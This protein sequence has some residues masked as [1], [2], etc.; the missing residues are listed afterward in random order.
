M[1]QLEGRTTEASFQGKPIRNFD[2]TF[3]VEGGHVVPVQLAIHPNQ[4][5]RIIVNV[6][7]VFGDIDGYADKYKKLATHV[8]SED[9]AAVVRTA[10]WMADSSPDTP[11]RAALQY[12]RDHA[13]EIAG[14]TEPEVMLMG[15]SAGASA[16]ASTA[17][18]YPEVTKILL[19]APSGDMGE[20]E[21]RQ[22]LREFGGEVYVVIGDQD[23]IVGPQAGP[24]FYEM[25][26]GA[27]FRDLSVIPDCGHQFKGETNGRIMSQAPFYAFAAGE[28]P[29]FPNPQ[30]GIVLYQ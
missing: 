5:R 1:A 18:L 17:H 8:Q 24:L 13:W 10:G 12:S 29:Q 9:L 25:A 7:G 22:G 19:L 2:G 4:S 30:G 3:Q 20:Q 14:D 15:F 27:S 26:T 11:L 6:P 28:K 16:I 23:E 21:V